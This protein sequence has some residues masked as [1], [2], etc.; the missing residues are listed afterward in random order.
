VIVIGA[1]GMVSIAAD[2]YMRVLL[3]SLP[4]CRLA[5]QRRVS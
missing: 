1:H 5:L 3:P 4:R 2:F